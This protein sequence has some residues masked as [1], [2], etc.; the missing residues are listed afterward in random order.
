LPNSH[1][2][3]SVS[4]L[5]KAKEYPHRQRPCNDK[6]DNGDGLTISI[7][8]VGLA[9]D[10][11]VTFKIGLLGFGVVG[12]GTAKIL[13]DPFGR[14]PVLK[15]ITIGRVGVRSLD[16][17]REIELSPQLL[18]T[19]LESIVT[20]PEIDIIV[21]LLGGLEPARSLI[22]Q[23]I[24]SG[25]H[26]VT[27]NKAVIARFGDEIYAKANE[28]GVYVLLEAAVGGGIPVIKPLKQ[29]LGANRISSIMG[30]VNGT[31]NYILTEMSQKGADFSE[32][33]GQ[34][35][36]IRLCRSGSHCGRGW[37]RCSR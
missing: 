31:T 15:E 6:I 14:H 4:G 19:D 8:C 16:K 3:S 7:V 12:T 29:S 18:T 37:I 1:H 9:G 36:G 17:P 22:L 2:L 25:K 34:S 11:S 13:L 10:K 26:V 33:S 30:I 20:D 23:A 27:A 35:S 32:V 21:E 24:A 28:K 5:R